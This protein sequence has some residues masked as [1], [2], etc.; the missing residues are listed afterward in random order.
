M[1]C[2]CVVVNV[3]DVAA[4]DF[5]ADDRDV[6]LAMHTVDELV[7]HSG[8]VSLQ[9]TAASASTPPPPLRS[10]LTITP[11]S[12]TPKS[13]RS[14]V[15]LV[16]ELTELRSRSPSPVH[17][18]RSRSASPPSSRSLV[19][20][21]MTGRSASSV[22]TAVSDTTTASSSSSSVANEVT[23]TTEPG[24]T[25]SGR[26]S[27]TSSRR[28]RKYSED[29]TSV[30]ST[31]ASTSSMSSSSADQSMTSKQHRVSGDNHRRDKHSTRHSP[32]HVTHRST[33]FPCFYFQL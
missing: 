20:E 6:Q 26:R 2:V 28:S 18:T 8:D 22:Q 11:R 15:R 7:A 25:G 4:L 29:F 33:I 9:H 12:L 13:S 14:R 27:S 1:V 16:D 23:S 21:Q 5:D 17:T 24:R 3:Q 30:A 31:S 32:L 10:I 19:S